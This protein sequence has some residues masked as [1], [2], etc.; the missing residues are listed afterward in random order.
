MSLILEKTNI[1]NK[2]KMTQ[3]NLIKE[4]KTNSKKEIT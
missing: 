2:N 4:L 3:R 1:K